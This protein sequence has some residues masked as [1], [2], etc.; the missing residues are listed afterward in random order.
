MQVES[1]TLLTARRFV[2]AKSLRRIRG[3]GEGVDGCS[4]HVRK[5]GSA[6]QMWA[7]MFRPKLGCWAFLT[8]P[9]WS[10]SGI[11]QFNKQR[12]LA[13]L[14]LGLIASCLAVTGPLQSLHFTSMSAWVPLRRRRG[15]MAANIAAQPNSRW[16][17]KTSTQVFVSPSRLAAGFAFQCPC[18]AQ[19]L[20][21]PV[22]SSVPVPVSEG[23]TARKECKL[24]RLDLVCRSETW[25]SSQ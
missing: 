12:F 9:P 6:R 7:Q 24:P 4:R 21:E 2:R 25:A 22:C 11:F 1:L 5:D 13:D 18:S 15:R 14:A 17:Q 10:Y 16:S 23:D 8:H 19:P 3:A 20:L